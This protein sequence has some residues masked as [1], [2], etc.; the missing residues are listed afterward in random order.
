MNESGDTA[1]QQAWTAYWSSGRLHSCASTAG[2]NYTGAI[3]AFWRGLFGRMELPARVL[4]LATGN[5][6]LPL[7][8]AELHGAGVEVDAVDLATVAPAWYDP[9]RHRGV[10]F[11]P[12]V[13]ME[14]LPFADASF[15]CIVS[16]FGFEYGDMEV[17]VAECS[18]VARPAAHIAFVMHHADSVLV[19]VGREELEHHAR[20][21]GE[22]GLVAAARGVV[23]WIA[24]ARAGEA[25]DAADAAHARARYN[26]AMQELGAAIANSSAPDLLLEVR[27][28]IHGLVMAGRDVQSML[29]AID[30]YASE[31]ERARLRTAEM[32]GHALHASQVERVAALLAAGRPGFV[33]EC[34]ELR[35]AE[36]VLAWSL[37]AGPPST[38]VAG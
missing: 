6:P 1:R 20:V 26:A 11:H 24:R 15:D 30:A 8:L 4:D 23:P 3:A 38:V 35:Q 14:A 13:R 27:E 25:V 31:L 12:R 32:I 21:L 10:R 36:G 34:A 22:G 28:T 33:V 37:V 16:Q 7:L 5:G 9:T 2:D 29:G 18:R 19:R 17:A